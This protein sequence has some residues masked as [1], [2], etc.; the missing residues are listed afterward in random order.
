[1][2]PRGTDWGL[3]L[4]VTLLFATGMASLFAAAPGDEWVFV[5]HDVLAFALAG[6]LVVKL[7][8]VWA[9]LVHPSEWD[10]Q[11]KAG[12][13]AT[14]FVAAALGSG[15]LWSG[16]GRVSVAGYT[17][18][19][20]HLVLGWVLVAAVAVHAYVR[21]RRL[22]GRD[23]ADRRQFLIAAGGGG[24]GPGRGRGGGGR[25]GRRAGAVAGAAA[26][27]RVLRIA[28]RRAAALHGLVRGGVVRGQRVSGD[29][30]GCG[31]AA[32]ARRG[33]VSPGGRRARRA[34]LVS[35]RE[36]AR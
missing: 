19:S 23:A 20:W 27:Q 15:W 10:R 9:R 14:I 36:R 21:A 29:L 35:G 18:L 16:G 13:L 33:H 31:R 30:M 34:P 12:V 2:T 3:A 8:R 24:G 25:S 5:A 11:V 7:R 26:G 17:L 6:L 22:R 4:V 1:M 28:F 32:G